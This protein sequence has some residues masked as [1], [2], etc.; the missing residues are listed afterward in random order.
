MQSWSE[1]VR[2]EWIIIE[3]IVLGLLYR[4]WRSIRRT[5][6]EDRARQAA[7]N[8]ERALGPGD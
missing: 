5:L 2:F 8:A 1:I 6:R 4:E 7:A 3:L